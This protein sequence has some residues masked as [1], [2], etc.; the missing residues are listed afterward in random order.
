MPNEPESAIRPTA[1]RIDGEVVVD[2]VTGLIWQREIDEQTRATAEAIAYCDSLILQGRDDWRLPERIELVSLMLPGSS[3]AIDSE[4]FPDT[5]A[6]YFRTATYAA[7]SD[8]RSWSVYFGSALVIVGSALSTSTYARC[9]TGEMV[10]LDPQFE[11]ME[12][13]ALDRG[14]E[15]VWRRDVQT[16]SSQSEAVDICDM[17]DSPPFRLP[18]VKELLT[19]VDDTSASPAIDE[20]IFSVGDSLTFWTSTTTGQNVRLVDFSQGATADASSPDNHAVRCV[21]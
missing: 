17:I 7:N 6:D 19:I 13:V 14:T 18:T 11:I 9:V 5:P 4:A 10:R 21:R 16:A 20:S 1:Y 3:P 2:E 12:S 15:L 8:E